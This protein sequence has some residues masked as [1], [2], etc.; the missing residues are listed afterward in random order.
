MPIQWT[1]GLDQQQQ[2]AQVVNVPP[3]QVHQAQPQQM[4]Q[5]PPPQQQQGYRAQMTLAQHNAVLADQQIQAQERQRRDA[6]AAQL[7]ISRDQLDFH[8]AQLQAQQQQAE[9]QRRQRMAEL[10]Q[11]QHFQGQQADLQ[12]GERQAEFGAQQQQGWAD[13]W[14]RQHEFDTGQNLQERI[15]G[16]RAYEFEKTGQEHA[17]Q[18]D[19]NNQFNRDVQTQKASE[20]GA[21]QDQAAQM[22]MIQAQAHAWLSQQEVGVHEMSMMRNLQYQAGII[23]NNPNLSD[24]A[25]ADLITQIAIKVNP[26][27]QRLEAQKQKQ[28]EQQ[29]E[30]GK[31]QI[32]HAT[33]D[34]HEAEKFRASTID[35][36][37]SP[38][39]M[40][41][42]YVNVMD[43][44]PGK[45][46]HVFD[47]SKLEEAKHKTDQ[48]LIDRKIMQESAAQKIAMNL[49][50]HTAAYHK[51][52]SDA[53]NKVVEGSAHPITGKAT[54]D[55]G[56]E[57][58]R[59]Y[60][61]YEAAGLDRK[62]GLPKDYLQLQQPPR[63]PMA[64]SIQPGGTW[65]PDNPPQQPAPQEPQAPSEPRQ[66]KPPKE[67]DSAAAKKQALAVAE[68]SFPAG[69]E[70]KKEHNAKHQDI[71]K[72][73]AVEQAHFDNLKAAYDQHFSTDSVPT[74]GEAL[75]A[76]NEQD[77]LNK[78]F[79]TYQGSPDPI[80]QK[81]ARLTDI[82]NRYADAKNGQQP[83]AA[84]KSQAQQYVAPVDRRQQAIEELK[85]R[86]VQVPEQ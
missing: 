53:A 28:M 43:M 35:Q 74:Q 20:W 73:D 76:K 68:E 9:M 3:P 54:T 33:I 14:E 39:L 58:E 30:M 37:I 77:K 31:L 84:P 10:Q 80:K 17:R 6:E 62:T 70:A 56:S 1:Y 72:M 69:L 21:Q 41:G 22:P 13:K 75:Q 50:N 57:L 61:Q 66:I 64:G 2:P 79:P 59:I 16:Q 36:R 82:Q 38:V 26:I 23:Q 45:A 85:R 55:H 12:R 24:E 29:L 52:V 46:P 44:G 51:S 49:A 5:G 65:Q 67:F 63:Q 81:K 48:M 4:V 8:Y 42:R 83:P 86:G 78:L 25:K 7:G 32:Q 34:Q 71:P 15:Q 40:N 11:Q 47:D 60:Q 19:E 27:T 18:F